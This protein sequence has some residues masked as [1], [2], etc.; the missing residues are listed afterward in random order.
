MRPV[1]SVHLVSIETTVVKIHSIINKANE[2]LETA[3]SEV[4]KNQ[5]GVLELRA[6]RPF[7]GETIHSMPKL[8]RF[9]IKMNRVIVAVGFIRSVVS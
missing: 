6:L 9:I 3:P 1:L 2:I 7:A 4:R 5:I 8:S